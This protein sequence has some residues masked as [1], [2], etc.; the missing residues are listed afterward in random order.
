METHPSV[1]IVVKAGLKIFHILPLDDI[2]IDFVCVWKRVTEPESFNR[3]KR[4]KGPLR[5]ARM[6]ISAFSVLCS[7]R[8]FAQNFD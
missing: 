6:R 8:A 1:D 2:W 3:N 5:T 4:E 7:A